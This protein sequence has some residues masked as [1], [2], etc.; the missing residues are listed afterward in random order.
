VAFKLPLRQLADGIFVW[1]KIGNKYLF[2]I[3]SAE[4]RVTLSILIKQLFAL[5][6]CGILG[7]PM[8]HS[9]FALAG[10]DEFM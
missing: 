2:L 9:A 5:I 8:L 3:S 10:S 7:K 1:K 6:F 4:V